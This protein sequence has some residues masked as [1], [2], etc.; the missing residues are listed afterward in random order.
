MSK[1]DKD[2]IKYGK[3]FCS[4]EADITTKDQD[5][6]MEIQVIKNEKFENVSIKKAKINKVAKSMRYFTGIFNSVLF[7]PQDI[8]LITGSPSER[9]KYMDDLLSQVDQGYK[10]SLSEYKR[11]VRQRNKLLEKI[12]KGFGGQNQIGFYT[13]SILKN[14]K[15]IQKKRDEMFRKINPVIFENGKILSGNGVKVEIKYKKN[16]IN[17]ERLEKYRDREI[18]AMTTLIGPHRDDFEIIFDNHDVSNFGSRG[19]QRSCVLALKISEIDFIEKE[20]SD[21]PV[22]LLDDIFSELDEKHQEAV[23]ETIKGKQTIIT[24]TSTPNF[25]GQNNHLL[26]NLSDR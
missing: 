18:A 10:N 6:N 16:E 23:L 7:S 25:L 21:T 26:I 24:S 11:G 13:D 15:L 14:G 9:R 2:Q 22:L 12:N 5:F 8:Q 4:V 20:K 19:E 3:P 1:Y 17:E